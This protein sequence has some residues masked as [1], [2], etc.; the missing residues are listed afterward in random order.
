MSS[1][2]GKTNSMLTEQE[3]NAIRKR[4]IGLDRNRPHKLTQEAILEIG[5]SYA[6]G[7]TATSL[8]KTYGVTVATIGYHLRKLAK[9]T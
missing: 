1:P 6:A 7:R 9:G 3:I 8:A 2:L 4:Q 5:R